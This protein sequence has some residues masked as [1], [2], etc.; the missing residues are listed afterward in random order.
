MT[1]RE[2][3]SRPNPRRRSQ[4]DDRAA[5]TET[6]VS[7]PATVVVVLVLVAV[8]IWWF[9]FAATPNQTPSSFL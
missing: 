8:A 2:M 5:R 9:F 3:Y 4:V 7:F 6:I 1:R